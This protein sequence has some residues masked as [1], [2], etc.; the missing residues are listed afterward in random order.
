[1]DNVRQDVRY[2]LRTL[3][4]DVGF[5]AMTVLTLAIGI[6]VNTAVFSVVR[7]VLLKPLAYHDSDRLVMLWT[8][9]A[10]QGV[11]EAASAYANV[12][13]WKAQN[14]VFEDLATFDPVSLTLTDGEWPEQ[15][16]AAKASANLFSVFGVAPA[17]GRT[18]T[19][20]EEQQRASVVVV[21]HELWQRRFNG[22]PSAVGQLIE[23][24]GTR[25][26]VIGVMP[27]S[28]PGNTQLWLPQTWFTDWTANLTQRGT[29]SWRVVGRLNSGVS[30]EE[31]RQEMNF[32]AARL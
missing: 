22:S 4:R 29:G 9:I 6:G 26:Q 10:S 1:M 15:I 32:I 18:F 21:S 7:S 3:R 28:F 16:S 8:D 19:A 27:E 23:I 31:A 5:A 20:E 14:R 11:H 25:F 17:T 12:Q 24:A 2:A 13:D 30:I